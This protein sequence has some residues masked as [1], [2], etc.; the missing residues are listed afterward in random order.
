MRR[1]AMVAL[2][3]IDLPGVSNLHNAN[4]QENQAQHFIRR[5]RGK[6]WNDDR[7]A[8]RDDQQAVPNE[9]LL[10]WRPRRQSLKLCTP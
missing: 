10:F 8:A 6:S 4:E 2:L 9:T 1:L 3:S 7:N 5:D